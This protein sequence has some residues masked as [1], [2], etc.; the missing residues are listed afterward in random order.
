MACL[1]E[2]SDPVPTGWFCEDW[3]QRDY[4]FGHRIQRRPE[5]DKIGACNGIARRAA[6]SDHRFVCDILEL[7]LLWYATTECNRHPTVYHNPFPE[8]DQRHFLR[9]RGLSPRSRVWTTR[10]TIAEYPRPSTR[11]TAAHESL[12]VPSPTNTPIQCPRSVSPERF[13]PGRLS[14]H[15][16]PRSGR[17]VQ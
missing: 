4:L 2:G 8:H 10:Q 17:H 15:R 13:S 3:W 16:R 5:G 7:A 9:F 11:A 12:S 1:R 6:L 14:R